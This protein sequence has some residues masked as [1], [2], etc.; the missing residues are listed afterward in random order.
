[1]SDLTDSDKKSFIDKI[2][3]TLTTSKAELTAKGW[4]PTQ[5]ITTLQNGVTSVTN[6]EGLVS[7]L[8]AALA[9]AVAT[10]RTDL[11]NNY[12]LASATVHLIEGI[13]GK[14]APLVRDLR[15]IR[16]GFSQDAK[17]VPAVK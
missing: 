1:M 9:T 3:A 14:D 6:D 17:P 2:L 7:Q 15:Q 4:D 12:A 10:R 13:L 5:R 16:G 11:D 8:D